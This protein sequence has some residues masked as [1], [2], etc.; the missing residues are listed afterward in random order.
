MFCH[1]S[2]SGCVC[3]SIT[4]I[5]SL[6]LWLLVCLC[7][8]IFAPIFIPAFGTLNST[9]SGV[10]IFTFCSVSIDTVF[11][12]ALDL[13]K[14]SQLPLAARSLDCN[15]SICFTI[16]QI[17]IFGSFFKKG[18]WKLYSLNS[19]FFVSLGFFLLPYN[20]NSNLTEYKIFRSA[21]LVLRRDLTLAYFFSFCK[22]FFLLPKG[23]LLYLWYVMV[24][25][26][27][28]PVLI[29]LLIFSWDIVYL[30]SLWL[31]LL[32]WKNFENCFWKFFSSIMV[33][34]KWNILHFLYLF[35]Y[36]L[37]PL[38]FLLFSHL[39]IFSQ[40]NQCLFFVLLLMKLLCCSSSLLSSAGSW[41]NLFIFPYIPWDFYFVVGCSV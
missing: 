38:S 22:W 27:Y 26:E 34:F 23:M 33:I 24:L 20:F 25:L 18:S 2:V 39:F 28:I 3:I 40:D 15:F 9:S 19:Y 32:L 7:I 1:C 29:V 11:V 35:P 16:G 12:L 41:D 17:L 10:I 36:A 13:V 21:F 8:S 6:E 14:W 4:W 31:C 37:F 30:Y 5:F